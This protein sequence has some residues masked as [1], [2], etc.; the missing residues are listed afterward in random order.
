MSLKK[1]HLLIQEENREVH[2]SNLD[3]N[4]I[5]LVKSKAGCLCYLMHS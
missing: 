5:A 3:M 2:L 4:I 1:I